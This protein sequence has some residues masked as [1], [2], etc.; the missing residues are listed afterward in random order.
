MSRRAAKFIGLSLM[1][2]ALL[3]TIASVPMQLA[4]SRV[5]ART[6]VIVGDENAPRVQDIVGEI[7]TRQDFGQAGPG[8]AIFFILAMCFVWIAVG[9]LIVSRQPSNW[10]G[11]IFIAVGVPFLLLGFCQ[12]AVSY[13][14][15]TSPGVIPFPAV[16]ALLGEYALFPVALIPLLFLLYPNG[17]VPG[18]RWRWAV[19]GLIGGTLLAFFGFLLRPG[20]LNNW[21]EQGILWVNPLGIDAL[22]PVGGVLIAIGAIVALV[23]AVSTAIAVIQRFRRSAGEQRQ[24]MRWL[25]LVGAIAGISFALNFAI[26]IFSA[27][28]GIGENDDSGWFVF[29][30][31]ITALTLVLGTPAAYLIAI[32]RY[33]L[34]DLDLVIRKTLQYVVLVV[35]FMLLG[36][37]IVAVVPALVLGVGSGTSIG[38]TLALAG[39]LTGVFLWLRPRATRLANRLVYGKRA[40]PY[41]VLSEFSERVGETYSTDDVLPR[42]AQ[43]VAEA[44]GATEAHVWLLV[45]NELRPEASWPADVQTTTRTLVGGTLD[46]IDGEYSADVRH[47]GDPLGAITLVPA[48]DDPMNPAKE[49]LVHDLAAQAGL[50]LRNV[51]LIEDL[52]ASRQRLVAAQDEE[53]RKLERNIHDGVQQQLVA[54]TVQLRLA[55]QLTERDPAKAR[56]LMAGLQGRTNEALEDLRD[57]A[58]GIYPPLL[59]DKG[60][61]TALEA[62]ARKSP[63][64][65]SVQADEMGRYPQAVESA[66]YFSCLEALNN[67]A[68]YADAGQ[69]SITLTHQNGSLT[70]DVADDGHG[71]DPAVTTYGTGLQG[72]ADRLDAIGGSMQID[73]EPTHGTTLHGIVPLGARL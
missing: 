13:E 36:F 35:A 16:W 57:L 44:T 19:R 2:V 64:P 5:D 55:E 56:E 49:K 32:Y 68:K 14:V 61:A 39:L 60:L 45:G 7:D 4:N 23:S 40:T 48:A 73:S 3:L 28:L 26:G 15:R 25:A 12:A 8:P 34:W 9:T 65:V 63:V 37:L 46:P 24:Q 58:R 30:L 41:E 62:Q 50:V 53:R 27:V 31:A 6:V 29:L 17:H 72:I 70:F 66:V 54:L 10:A 11:W 51:R 67:V 38:P 42:M 18:P 47:Q 52:R 1:A 20:P 43:L 22:A 59:A 71:F 33:G 21:V 69:V